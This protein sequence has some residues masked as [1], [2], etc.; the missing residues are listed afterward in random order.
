MDIGVSDPAAAGEPGCC[1]RG[2]EA[3]EKVGHWRYPFGLRGPARGEPAGQ[4]RLAE[5]PERDV[6]DAAAAVLAQAGELP[7]EGAGVGAAPVNVIA[8]L[9][10]CFGRST[11]VHVV[12]SLVPDP[13]AV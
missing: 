10:V 2:D 1:W 8:A 5:H 3:G 6:E 13:G 11:E 9:A 12:V 4:G 7:R